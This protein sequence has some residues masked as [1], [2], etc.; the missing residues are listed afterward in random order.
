M[1]SLNTLC[2][3]FY[4]ATTPLTCLHSIAV[5]KQFLCVFIH[6]YIYSFT[7]I[8]VLQCF[9]QQYSV[10]IKY[11]FYLLYNGIFFCLFIHRI[12]HVVVYCSVYYA[13]I[14]EIFLGYEFFSSCF[15][16]LLCPFKILFALNFSNIITFSLPVST[17]PSGYMCVILVSFYGMFYCFLLNN[18]TLKLITKSNRVSLLFY[19]S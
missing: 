6:I 1:Y 5:T 8:S 3:W 16:Y 19:Y 4:R 14:M 18:Q 15:L 17:E 2:I 12:H 11:N 10:L 7:F 13:E 9:K